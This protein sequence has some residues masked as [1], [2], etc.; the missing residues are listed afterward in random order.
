MKS[1]LK[2]VK[3]K[4]DDLKLG[5]NPRQI[6]FTSEE[7]ED[8]FVSQM[9]RA[10]PEYVETLEVFEIN[11]EQ[12]QLHSG[13]RRL[14]AAKRLK[15]DFVPCYVLT[16]LPP[17]EAFYRA[18]ATNYHRNNLSGFDLVMSVVKLQEKYKQTQDQIAKALGL[19]QPY[20]SQLLIINTFPD[21]LK[22]LKENGHKRGT[23]GK[24]VQ[25]TRIKDKNSRTKILADTDNYTVAQLQN[26][27]SSGGEFTEFKPPLESTTE[28]LED[29]TRIADE[30]VKIEGH[31]SEDS[32]VVHPI[33]TSGES[34]GDGEVEQPEIS[35]EKAT[36]PD[37][38]PETPSED[39]TQ[40]EEP[41]S[42]SPETE[43]SPSKSWKQG[44]YHPA[45]GCFIENGTDGIIKMRNT[46]T[47]KDITTL[48]RRHSF[49][50]SN[51]VET[52]MLPGEKTSDFLIR[53]IY[54]PHKL[55]DDRLKEALIHA[56]EI[57]VKA[58]V[59]LRALE[60]LE[61]FNGRMKVS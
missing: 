37:G 9:E 46:H 5:E 39:Q 29:E 58:P 42:T 30:V 15:W 56:R 27:G 60:N 50:M 34:E 3:V 2:L 45:C 20:V 41:A 57:K 32:S 53:E 6:L 7:D 8:T 43:S 51:L 33:Q 19:S 1:K 59:V 12:Y 16:L 55:S 49:L 28:A 18:I 23:L 14:H 22:F 17:K 25:L 10:G 13:Y 61:R 54:D 4:P 21:V 36:S 26:I 52:K 31:A 47:C 24:A 44:W 48:L 40:P 11:N 35:S 38:E